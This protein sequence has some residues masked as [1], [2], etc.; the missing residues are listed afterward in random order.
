MPAHDTTSSATG[1]LPQGARISPA[2]SAW[3]LAGITFLAMAAVLATGRLEPL[4]IGLAVALAVI[5]L[6]AGYWSHRRIARRL[7]ALHESITGDCRIRLEDL[8]RKSGIAGL[9]GLCSQVLPVWSGQIEMARSHMEQE[10]IAL[11]QRFADISQRLGASVAQLDSGGGGQGES[12]IALLQGAQWD[13]DAIVSG[14]KNALENKVALLDEITALSAHTEELRRMAKDVGDIANQTNLL[15]LNAAIEAARAGEAG[16]G[17]A[18]VADEVRKLST[19]SGETGKKIGATVDTVN[20][21]IAHSLDIS[22]DYAEQDKALADESSKV[23]GEVI[24]HFS[25]AATGLAESSEHLRS[26][27]VAIGQEIDNVLIA[28]QFQDRVSQVLNHVNQ[29]LGKLKQKIDDGQAQQ[30]DGKDHQPI[31]A[32]RWLDE[33]SQT[34][35]MPEQHLIHGGG[36]RTKTKAAE[37]NSGDITFF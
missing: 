10:T 37:S 32:G 28:L 15:A 25:Q 34:Y 14:L 36:T 20:T 35:T 1:T 3:S 33:L 31:E 30:R 27:S 22:K 23:I 12:L 9:D 11:T 19:L 7:L 17:F 24:A 21:A 29:D 18:V 6:L 5:A 4:A 16:R 8:R 2:V 13:L 26:E